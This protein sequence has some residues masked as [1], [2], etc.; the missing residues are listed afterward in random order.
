M[1]KEASKVS[2]KVVLQEWFVGAWSDVDSR[3]YMCPCCWPKDGRDLTTA[4]I[5]QLIED[6]RLSDIRKPYRIILRT[7]KP[8]WVSDENKA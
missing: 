1:N 7:E 4:E 5:M 2:R 6:K 3:K 8:I